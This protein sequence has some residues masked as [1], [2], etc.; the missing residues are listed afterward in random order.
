MRYFILMAGCLFFGNCFSQVSVGYSG[1]MTRFQ[2]LSFVQSENEGYLSLKKT[3]A[4]LK[5]KSWNTGR[6]ILT[7]QKYDKDYK[8][9]TETN[10]AGGANTFNSRYSELVKMGNKYWLLYLEPLNN[11]DM[12]DIKAIEIN[13][14]TLE[15]KEAKT[16]IPGT[17]LNHSISKITESY[18]LSFITG[19][20][21]AAKYYYLCVRMS[22]EVHFFTCVDENMKAAWNK[23]E[24]IDGIKSGS[25]CSMEADDAGNLYV[26]YVKKAGLF[27]SVY[28]ANGQVSTKEIRLAAGK[29]KEILFFP[30]KNS[31]Q[32]LVAGTYMEDDNCTGVFKG[33]FKN[34]EPADITT[35]AFPETIIQPL[36]KEG[37]AS[38][39]S[40]KFG[41]KPSFLA[42]PVQ[43][44][45]GPDFV[46]E[47][48]LATSNPGRPGYFHSGSIVYVDFTAAGVV[49]T[50]VP[51][52]GLGPTVY[53][54]GFNGR[55]E[56]GCYYYAFPYNAKMI[57][58]YFDTPENLNRDIALDAKVSNAGNTVLM[59]AVIE[60]DGTLKRQRANTS[61]ATDR[62]EVKVPV[63]MQDKIIIAS[64]AL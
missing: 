60:K 7:L 49:F 5:G 31:N 38:T 8:L 6:H 59:A 17:A 24:T 13:P 39:K 23:K 45:D 14:A 33:V 43:G 19:L 42:T 53:E 4:D 62:N 40:K 21:P 63:K 30:V 54:Y 52:Y 18:A 64:V 11:N 58:L 48:S 22:E 46:M 12:G 44:N 26:A 36:D 9:L 27:S 15:Q 25:I 61:N 51:R 20:S 2:N 57:I 28:S 16:V 56:T 29:A 55:F 47:F 35:T 10:V 50:R 34:G 3:N 41:A 32:V 37:W 1:V